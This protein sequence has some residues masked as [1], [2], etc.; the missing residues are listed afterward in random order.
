MSVLTRKQFLKRSKTCI[1]ETG[2]QALLISELINLEK[3]E[4]I[5]NQEA[6]KKIKGIMKGVETAFF[7]YE[8]LSPPD[9]CVSL[10]LK[11]LHSL[12]TLQESIA[13]NYDF[14]VFSDDHEKEKAEK[15]EESRTLLD[16]FRL[17]FRPI[18]TEVDSLLIK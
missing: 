4:K 8:V 2:N 5:D 14:V 3:E 12:I 1:N 16:K 15:L 18:T 13:A 10:H 9:N 11:I 6:Y 17:E 7:R